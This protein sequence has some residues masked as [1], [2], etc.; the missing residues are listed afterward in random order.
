M[1]Q[2]LVAVCVCVCETELVFTHKSTLT[3]THTNTRTHPLTTL[4]GKKVKVR[5]TDNTRVFYGARQ[6]WAEHAN[7]TQ[8]D[9]S[10]NPKHNCLNMSFKKEIRRFPC[11]PTKVSYAAA[12][13]NHLIA[14]PNYRRTSSKSGVKFS[15]SRSKGQSRSRL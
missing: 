5:G 12:A 10:W 14:F 3:H 9:L 11:E 4:V 6:T 13:P 2:T 7:A 15:R 8:K 1:C